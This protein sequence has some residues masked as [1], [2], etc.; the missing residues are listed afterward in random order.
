MTVRLS[1]EWAGKTPVIA[2]LLSP[3][4]KGK[5]C[6]WLPAA[7]HPCTYTLQASVWGFPGFLHTGQGDSRI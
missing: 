6:P 1:Y 4:L 2:G 3:S 5:F 7:P